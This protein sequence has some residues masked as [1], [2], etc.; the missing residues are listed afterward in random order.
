MLNLLK[1]YNKGSF[2]EGIKYFAGQEGFSVILRSALMLAA[3][4]R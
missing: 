4:T 3:N 1:H 2:V